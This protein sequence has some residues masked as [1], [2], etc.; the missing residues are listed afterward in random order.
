MKDTKLTKHV[1]IFDKNAKNTNKSIFGEH[2]SLLY[3][4]EQ[5]PIWYDLYSILTQNF[6]V[7]REVNLT[8]DTTDWGTKMSDVEKQFYKRSISQLVLLDSIATI[9]DGVFA[10]YIQNPAIKAIMSYIAS[11]EAIHN[12][13]YTYIATTFMTKEEATEVFEIPKTD[14]LILGASE[15]I[16]DQFEKF[17][18]YPTRINMVYALVAMAALEGIRFTN[19]FTPFYLLNRNKKMMGSG[20]IITLIQREQ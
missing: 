16:L 12:E 4:D 5:N 3:W 7:A 10:S 18:K 20:Q 2:S 13:S 1:R 11:Q 9:A 8:S 6:W 19:G 17:I 14:G 15:L